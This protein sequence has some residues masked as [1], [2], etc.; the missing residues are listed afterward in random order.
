MDRRI[1]IDLCVDKFH[2]ISL[3]IIVFGKQLCDR[4]SQMSEMGGF[5]CPKFI[6][7]TL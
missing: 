6:I 5:F 1:E 2:S 7:T 4:M 3:F